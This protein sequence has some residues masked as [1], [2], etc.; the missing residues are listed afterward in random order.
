MAKN[1]E[2]AEKMRI[3]R[4]QM[5]NDPDLQAARESATQSILEKYAN[6]GQK[7]ETG[8]APEPEQYDAETSADKTEAKVPPSSFGVGGAPPLNQPPIGKPTV[9]G[10]PT[11]KVN[12]RTMP[13]GGMR[14][15]G[16]GG[17]RAFAPSPPDTAMPAPLPITPQMRVDTTD[18]L[19]VG[20][21]WKYAKGGRVS[22][23]G[24]ASG[25]DSNFGKD[26]R[27]GK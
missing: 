14:G 18:P 24:F 9:P 13:R 5:E 8:G 3:K 25:G 11:V 6:E 1:P 4:E 10:E 17:G 2:R 7:P 27:K 12:P 22:N 21:K 23:F 19:G 26:Y 20:P 16:G 15:R